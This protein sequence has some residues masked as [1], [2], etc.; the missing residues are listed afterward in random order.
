MNGGDISKTSRDPEIRK[1]MNSLGEAIGSTAGVC[2]ELEDRL[3]PILNNSAVQIGPDIT[4]PHTQ[5]LFTPMAQD[6]LELVNEVNRI[7]NMMLII[8]EQIEL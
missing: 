4:K 2:K 6:L 5:E 7:R 3:K 1:T 8:L